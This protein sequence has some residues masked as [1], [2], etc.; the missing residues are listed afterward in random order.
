MAR[1]GLGP[2]EAARRFKIPER[3]IHRDLAAL[4]AGQVVDLT[5]AE[6]EVMIRVLV[7]EFGETSLR[8]G[9]TGQ[10]ELFDGAG[11]VNPG[12]VPGGVWEPLSLPGLVQPDTTPT[13]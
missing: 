1:L 9:A 4:R 10:G 2:L 13:H 7:E 6:W 11:Y 5:E 3:I 12:Q 8:P